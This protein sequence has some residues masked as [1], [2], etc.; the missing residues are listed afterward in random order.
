[1]N[2]GFHDVKNDFAKFPTELKSLYTIKRDWPIRSEII[3]MNNLHLMM[4]LHHQLGN[5]R[6][7][8]F[9]SRWVVHLR[10]S[11]TLKLKIITY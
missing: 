10:I 7:I 4:I 11:I 5:T 9:S 3:T 8:K 2:I 6:D 1:M